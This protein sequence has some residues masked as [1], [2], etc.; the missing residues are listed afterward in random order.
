[1]NKEKVLINYFDSKQYNNQEILESVEQTKK[2]FEKKIIN[3]EIKLNEYGDYVITY[4]FR[5]KENFLQKIIIKLKE[6]RKSK[7]R[8]L[9][10]E[11]N[12]LEQVL[13]SEKNSNIRFKEK[14]EK[15]KLDN[16]KDRK[17]KN[18][19]KK[20]EKK[21]RKQRQEE[22]LQKRIEKYTGNQYGKYKPTKTYRP[23]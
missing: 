11:E 8:L 20:K 23:Y 4:Y 5:T 12:I 13:E 15:N 6:R 16:K 7:N 17:V 19:K 14:R 10:K 1:M 9:L 3:V 2:E 21:T 22:K 18:K